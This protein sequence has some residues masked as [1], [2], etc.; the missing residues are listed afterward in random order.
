MSHRINASRASD[1]AMRV[2]LRG[3]EPMRLDATSAKRAVM[4]QEH[5]TPSE[6][7]SPVY[8]RMMF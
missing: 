5:A 7:I 8:V 4:V 2:T 3:S 1:M 6:M